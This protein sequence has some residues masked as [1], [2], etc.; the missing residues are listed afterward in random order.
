MNLILSN[1][2]EESPEGR[3]REAPSKGERILLRGNSPYPGQK[4]GAGRERGP[5]V[6]K[7]RAMRKSFR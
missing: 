1:E 3:F 7:K 2:R 6:W 4:S 5:C